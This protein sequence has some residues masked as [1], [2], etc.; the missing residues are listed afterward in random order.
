MAET[1][2]ENGKDFKPGDYAYVPDS[3]KPSTWKLRLTNTPGGDPDPNIV[4][5]AV[6]ALGKGFRGNKVQIPSSDRAKVVAKVRNAWKS[7][8]KGK[9]EEEMPDVLKASG[10][11]ESLELMSVAP[12][13]WE[14]TIKKMKKVRSEAIDNPWALAWWMDKKGYK[15][16]GATES[17][18]EA[19]ANSIPDICYAAA[20]GEGW[21]QNQLL[22][23]N[24]F[25]IYTE[26]R[27]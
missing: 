16:G 26:E 18:M 24:G 14:E 1:K 5:A 7:A 9:P 2:R 8:N 27:W 3:S 21:A 23:H 25:H 17:Q 11:Y 13:G 19:L 10:S 20:R 4:G 22:N 12:P 15:P 6:A